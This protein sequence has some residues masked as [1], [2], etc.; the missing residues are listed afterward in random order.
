MSMTERPY[1]AEHNAEVV[2]RPSF[3]KTLLSTKPPTSPL[4]EQADQ[5]LDLALE[6]LT[7]ATVEHS[8][9]CERV[10]RRQQ[11]SGSLKIVLAAE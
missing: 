9:A 1:E 5:A 8:E 3:I 2:P 6:R 10:H 7:S 4:T 11:S